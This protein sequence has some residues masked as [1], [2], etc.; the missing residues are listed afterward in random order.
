MLN[1]CYSNLCE[2]VKL[3][4]RK[5]LKT[6][7]SEDMYVVVYWLHGFN[8]FLVCFFVLCTAVMLSANRNTHLE[9][10]SLHLLNKK[11]CIQAHL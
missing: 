4:K 11:T 1:C 7:P 9:K 10:N 3:V 5:T 6:H 8:P 2:A